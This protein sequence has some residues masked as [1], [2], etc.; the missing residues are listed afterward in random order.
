MISKIIES[1][2]SCEYDKILYK[3][4]GA[5]LLLLSKNKIKFEQKYIYKYGIIFNA[6]KMYILYSNLLL[7]QIP[8]NCFLVFITELH[9]FVDCNQYN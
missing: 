7:K 6:A 2:A 5:D 1:T 4:T 9:N 8:T 3:S